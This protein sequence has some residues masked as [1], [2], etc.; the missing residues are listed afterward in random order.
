M[1][2]T[3]NKEMER[4]LGGSHEEDENLGRQ[5]PGREPADDKSTGQQTSDRE[6]SRIGEDEDRDRSR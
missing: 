6:N 4:K 5:S 3:Q 2:N 1:G